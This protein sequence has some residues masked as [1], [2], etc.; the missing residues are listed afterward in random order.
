MKK[1][2]KKII[3]TL[4]CASFFMAGS[5]MAQD[6]AKENLI[7]K[8]GTPVN[9]IQMEDGSEKL[10]FGPKDS[11]I[12][13]MYFVVNNGSVVSKGTTDDAQFSKKA[14]SNGPVASGLMA[15][16]YKNNTV[17]KKDLVAKYSAP[18]SEKT[19]KNGVE[20]VV[21]GP[22]DSTIGYLSFLVKDGNVISAGTT[23]SADKSMVVAAKTERKSNSLTAKYYTNNN[24]TVKDIESNWGAPQK[25][26][27]LDN[28]TEKRVYG[29]KDSMIGYQYFLS[30]DGKV[31]DRGVTDSI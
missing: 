7:N 9:A 22:K 14:A 31:V 24:V 6:N 18:V 17:A 4:T 30:L 1:T 15:S 12:G 13:Y 25:V 29:P 19:F 10:V 3:M 23:D 11:V 27:K 20:R 5:A 16:Y 21:F 8:W 2:A 26:E 28:G